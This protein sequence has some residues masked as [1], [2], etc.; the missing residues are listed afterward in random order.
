MV[1]KKDNEGFL[2]FFYVFSFLLLF[3]QASFAQKFRLEVSKI[4]SESSFRALSVVDDSVAWLAGTKGTIAST[5][6]RGKSWEIK[7]IPG[8]ST[9]DFRTL[10]AFD[11]KQLVVANAG[12][13]ACILRSTDAGHSWIKVYEN[14]DSAAF[15][16]SIDFWNEREGVIYGDPIN[17]KILLLKTSDSG[18]TWAPIHGAPVVEK[19]EA[20]FAASGTGISCI[21]KSEIW[22]ATGGFRSR[23]WKSPNRGMTW[24]SLEVPVIQGKSSTGIFSFAIHPSGNLV[25]VGGDYLSDSLRSK[26]SFFS[27]DNGYFWQEAA[28]T[29]GGYRECVRILSNDMA[30]ALGPGGI[31]FSN[32]FG[33][34][35]QPFSSEKGFHTLA[36]SR[37][38]NWIVLAGSKGMVGFLIPQ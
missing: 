11:A 8:F 38:G 20:S 13:P 26:V 32:N 17:G 29:T 5:T 6:N 25:V 12:S 37:K 30:I 10:Y 15:F 2:P 36:H 16:D 7:T 9:F 31:D 1:V 18:L 27:S 22:L 19:G 33:K 35:W 4:Q 14:Q 28:P 34:S 3:H 21:R 23:L 24:S